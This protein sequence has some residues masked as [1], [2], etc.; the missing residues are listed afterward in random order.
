MSAPAGVRQA[1]IL[2]GGQGTRMRPLTDTL[3]KPMLPLL[4]LPFVERQVDHLSAAGV[5]RVVFSCGYRPREIE[6]YFGDGASRGLQVGYVVDPEPLGTAGAIA[7]AEELLDDDDVFVL[8]GDILTDLDLAALVAHHRGLGA[9]ATIA[10]TPVDD[11]SAFGLVRTDADGRVT[12]FV[13]KPGA[14]Q[15]VPGEPYRINAG[16][17]V[18]SPSARRAIPHGQQ[19]SIERDTFPLLAARGGVGA[20]A[21]DCYWR[22]IGTPGSYLDAHLDLLSGRVGFIPSPGAAWVSPDALV[23]ASATI[24]P[25]ACVGP[26][27]VVGAGATVADCV[28][29]AGTS[30]GE[31]AMVDGAV[32]GRQV[33]VGPGARVTGLVVAGD[34]AMVPEGMAVAGPATIPTGSVA[35]P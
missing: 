7:N 22:D 11:P 34:G 21:S 10:L 35:S 32:L 3:P 23:D 26:G 8:N 33:T 14:D 12:E 29:G 5:E 27:A 15:L 24:G 31:E 30:V 4:D 9:E 25:G 28:V 2:V 6:E 19:V 20:M 17:Y 16:T 13:E 1:V 18:L